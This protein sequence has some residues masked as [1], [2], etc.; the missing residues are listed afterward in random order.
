MGEFKLDEGAG[1]Q[2]NGGRVHHNHSLKGEEYAQLLADLRA[3]VSAANFCVE[4][5][6]I[7]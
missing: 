6:M 3:A 2:L 1:I 5:S 4:V 7:S